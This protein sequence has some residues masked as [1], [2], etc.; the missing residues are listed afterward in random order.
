MGTEAG[1]GQEPRRV[2]AV[3]ARL[4]TM[5]HDELRRARAHA[6]AVARKLIAVAALLALA[7]RPALNGGDWD[8]HV[9]L[10][11]Q[12]AGRAPSRR[13]TADGIEK[14]R[15]RRGGGRGFTRMARARAD[16]R[17][18]GR[19]RRGAGSA[20]LVVHEVVE[21]VAQ[22]HLEGLVVRLRV[23]ADVETLSCVANQ[24]VKT[25]WKRWSLAHGVWI[26]KWHLSTEKRL[27]AA[28]TCCWMILV[29][30]CASTPRGEGGW[31]GVSGWMGDGP[32]SSPGATKQPHPA[33]HII[34]VLLQC[35]LSFPPPR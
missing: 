31:M 18:G 21:E 7:A 8:G 27:P 34:P 29:M 22:V 19:R 30:M 15:R 12:V 9:M 10:G 5:H 23:G 4:L 2:G 25:P 1:A 16:V 13:L 32:T 20:D 17:A 3:H 6:A 14:R 24:R 11:L 26:G 35:D 28:L 33:A